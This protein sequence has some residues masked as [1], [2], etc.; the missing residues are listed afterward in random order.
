MHNSKTN[1]SCRWSRSKLVPSAKV[2]VGRK[3]GR[4]SLV[5][6]E[7]PTAVQSP[8]FDIFEEFRSQ[9]PAPRADT[10]KTPPQFSN[11]PKIVVMF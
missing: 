10:R 7:G 9:T 4:G 11:E 2:P 6:P 5:A 1:R 8:G 3:R